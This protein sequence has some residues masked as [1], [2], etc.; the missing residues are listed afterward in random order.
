M[1]AQRIVYGDWGLRHANPLALPENGADTVRIVPVDGD[2]SEERFPAVPVRFGLQGE[3]AGEVP[4]AIIK[5]EA[6]KPR[7]VALLHCLDDGRALFTDIGEG[8]DWPAGSGVALADR[9]AAL[10]QD[11]HL[12]LA[13]NECWYVA[14]SA[15]CERAWRISSE[16]SFQALGERLFAALDEGD[17]APFRPRFRVPQRLCVCD[18]EVFW[19]GT[20]KAGEPCG[21]LVEHRSARHVCWDEPWVTVDQLVRDE[22]GFLRAL[23][24]R[25]D[26]ALKGRR[27]ADLAGGL[28]ASGVTRA[29]GWRRLAYE[30]PC[31]SG[32]SGQVCALSVEALQPECELGSKAGSKRGPLLLRISHDRT[33]GDRTLREGPEDLARL[34]ESLAAILEEE[35]AATSPWTGWLEDMAGA[36][37]GGT[38]DVREERT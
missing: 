13:N 1:S 18:V 15:P 16:R 27:G 32:L 9:I 17:C 19:G 24:K 10:S 36:G 12:R 6:D 38:G 7:I 34:G 20:G 14:P 2:M 8:G 23:G 5:G 21:V 33:R 29:G 28:L 11:W 4:L 25:C 3:G 26:M 30:V 35:G 37:H 22:D 31:E